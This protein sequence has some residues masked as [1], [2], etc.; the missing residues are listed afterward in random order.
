MEASSYPTPLPSPSCPQTAIFWRAPLILVE[1]FKSG[2]V[3]RLTREKNK[4]GRIVVVQFTYLDLIGQ[5]V[6][7]EY[8]PTNV[9]SPPPPPHLIYWL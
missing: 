2:I 3:E 1:N 4:I 5:L 8:I 6:G 9:C 7:G